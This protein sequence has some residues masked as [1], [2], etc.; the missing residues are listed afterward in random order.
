VEIKTGANIYNKK[1]NR[2]LHKEVTKY[3]EEFRREKNSG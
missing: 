2:L 3:V 1:E